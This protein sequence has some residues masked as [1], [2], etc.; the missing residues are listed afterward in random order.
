M[1]VINFTISCNTSSDVP[2]NEVEA[3]SG[4]SINSEQKSHD[5]EKE[6]PFVRGFVA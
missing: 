2:L 6:M 4:S 1:P 5:R 3:I